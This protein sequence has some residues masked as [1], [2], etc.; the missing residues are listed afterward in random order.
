MNSKSHRILKIEFGKTN[1]GVV[2]GCEEGEG[3][4]W[5]GIDNFLLVLTG[6]GCLPSEKLFYA[7]NIKY[8]T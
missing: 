6:C 3:R 4:D 7:S 5:G 1:F 8:K 2:G